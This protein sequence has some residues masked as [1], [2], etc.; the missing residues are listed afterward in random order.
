MKLMNLW[1]WLF[2]VIFTLGIA[3]YQRTTGPT[4]P[5]KGKVILEQNLIRYRLIR[6]AE[7]TGNAEVKVT[8]PD[9]AIFGAIK[10]RR[11]GTNDEWTAFPMVRQGNNLVGILP[12]Q[13]PAGKLEYQVALTEGGHYVLLTE[14]PVVIRFK[15][16][17]PLFVLIP[18]IIIIF[19]AML[20]STRTAL[21]AIFRKK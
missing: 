18:H 6:S 16:A 20:M 14:K 13:P 8:V 17:V 4:Y 3:Y 2:S 1:L 21:E 11:F 9:T 15:G 19:A 10:Y 5:A 7:S 12:V